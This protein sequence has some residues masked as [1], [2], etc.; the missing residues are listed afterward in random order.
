M[1][2]QFLSFDAIFAMVIFTFAVSLLAFIWYT[3]NSQIAIG[4]G[5]SVQGMQL[6]LEAVSEKILGTGYPQNWYS[7]VDTSNSLTWA[8]ISVG[9]GSG[10]GGAISNS[11]LAAFS[12][13]ANGNYLYT[14]P[15]L[16]VGYD[17]YIVI[18]TSAYQIAIGKKPAPQV[19][20]AL[21]GVTLQ[22]T[23]RSVTINGQ[24]A[25]MQIFIW[26]NSSFGIG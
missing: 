20:S 19:G 6:Q 11:K 9:L 23:S 21:N 22:S 10:V 13:M 5:N 14:K 25:N 18:S 26:T 3:I 4:S 1:R 24:P 16:G 2:L 7:T 12:S 15:L 17:Y 8:N